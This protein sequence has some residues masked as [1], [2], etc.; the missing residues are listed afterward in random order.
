MANERHSLATYVS[1]MLALEELVCAAFK[2]QA[3]DKDYAACGNAAAVVSRLQAQSTQHIEALK[4]ELKELGGHEAAGMKSA[5]AS[6]EGMFAGAY[7]KLRKTKVAKG[8]RDDYAG[9]ALC[10]VSYAEL[11]STACGFHDTGAVLLAETHMRNYT[12]LCKAINEAIPEVVALEIKRLELDFDT[13]T[14]EQARETILNVWKNEPAEHAAS[15]RG[16]V[17]PQGNRSLFAE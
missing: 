7:G 8:L 17:E 13:G 12:E 3:S 2:L 9:L 1:D 10:I 16:V 14:I 6:A 5:A 11:L 4:R 15:T